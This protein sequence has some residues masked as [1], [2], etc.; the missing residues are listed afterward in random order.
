MRS[1]S[2]LDKTL[3][4]PLQEVHVAEPPQVRH[5]EPD[6]QMLIERIVKLQ[7]I[8]ARKNEKIEFLEDHINQLLLE[9]KKKNR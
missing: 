3:T 5:V 8:H 7:R 9:I 2:Q 1:A 6:K 4:S